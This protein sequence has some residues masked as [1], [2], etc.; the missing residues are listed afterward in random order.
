M[1]PKVKTMEN[2]SLQ[3]HRQARGK[4]EIA[5]K[6]PLDTPE[7]LSLAYTPG[8][9]EVCQAIHKSPQLL[10][11][12][13]VQ[14]NAVAVVTDGSAVLG[15]GDIGPGAAMPVMEGKCA[16][17]KKLAGVDAWPLCLDAREPDEIVDL[18][19]AIAPGFAGVNLEDISAPRCFEIEDRLQ[20]LGIP[21]MHD[22]QH[23]TAIVLLAGLMN[24][25]RVTGKNFSD[26]K[27][28]VAGAGAAGRAIARILRCIGQ[29]TNGCESV[30]EIIV[31]DS[32]GALHSGRENLGPVKEAI[33][34]YSNSNNRTG[35]LKEVIEGADVFIGVSGPGILESDDIRRM[36]EDP[37]VFALA[38]PTPEIMPD[39]A[40]EAGAAIVAT[41]R[42]DFPN[43]VNNVLA[44]PGIFRGAIDA[45]AARITDGMKIAASR[46]IAS[47]IRNPDPDHILPGAL[48]M[49]VASR[50]A[51]HVHQAAVAEK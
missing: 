11:D 12:L 47:A 17:F 43:Q 34:E 41:G 30:A 40:K 3:L 5:L 51:E 28:V 14:G 39:V 27:V 4:I 31:C 16:L 7:D 29:E 48:S 19:R 13:T 38:N 24:A 32:R 21:V 36:A 46:A 25:T 45:G 22:D 37:Y 33:L 15:L 49:E 42:S 1:R 26:L 9:G 35:T 10:G 23:G 8:V 6:V 44:F 20:D 50:V 18:I 2:K